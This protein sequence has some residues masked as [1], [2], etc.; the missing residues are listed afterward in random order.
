MGRVLGKSWPGLFIS[1][2]SPV[3]CGAITVIWVSALR[4]KEVDAYGK[5]LQP[6]GVVECD[7]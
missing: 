2:S 7:K 3:Q 5:L 6:E 1:R 4:N